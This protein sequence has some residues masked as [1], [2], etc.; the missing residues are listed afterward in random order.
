MGAPICTKTCKT[1]T[2]YYLLELVPMGDVWDSSMSSGTF[3]DM[4][5]R[6]PT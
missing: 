2:P 1:C 3:H 5:A 4:P 6:V